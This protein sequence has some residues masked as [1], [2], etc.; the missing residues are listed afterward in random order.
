MDATTK[1]VV[2][3]EV[4]QD[5]PDATTTAETVPETEA[6]LGALAVASEAVA[7]SEATSA[8]AELQAA[9][10]IEL[11][12]RAFG[13]RLG[14]VEKWREETA[15]ALGNLAQ[16]MQAMQEENTK[17]REILTNE[18]AAVQTKLSSERTKPISELNPDES[19]VVEDRAGPARKRHR[20]I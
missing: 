6:A 17:T 9:E 4:T 15:A 18:L 3:E 12:G 16:A 7:L 14:E 11:A 13:E 2:T 19:V 5:V 8:A 1:R 10:T 20:L